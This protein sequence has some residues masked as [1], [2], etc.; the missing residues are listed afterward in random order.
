MGGWGQ[1][2]VCVWLLCLDLGFLGLLKMD[3][4]VCVCIL[5]NVWVCVYCFCVWLTRNGKKMLENLGSVHNPQ[6]NR[7]PANPKDLEYPQ[8]KQTKK[9]IN[10]HISKAKNSKTKFENSTQQQTDSLNQQQPNSLTSKSKRK[11]VWVKDL[12][13]RKSKRTRRGWRH[14]DS[15]LRHENAGHHH[16]HYLSLSLSNFSNQHEE[17]CAFVGM[18]WFY[19]GVENEEHMFRSSC[20][21]QK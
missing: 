4:W 7:S 2:W 6:L 8:E 12:A 14:E 9:L 5:A 19:V 1:I 17:P 10:H 13:E 20:S 16:H 15:L 21:S 3:C 18:S 11:V